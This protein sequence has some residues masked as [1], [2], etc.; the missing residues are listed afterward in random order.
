VASDW[1]R[2]D[3]AAAKYGPQLDS[4]ASRYTDPLTGKRLTGEAL[5]RKTIKL[6]SGGQRDAVSSAGARGWAQFMP[7]TRAAVIH[8]FGVDP[9]R[10][11]EE[12]VQALVLHQRGK[13]GNATGLE[14]YNPGGGRAYVNEVLGARVGPGRGGRGGVT[15]APTAGAGGAAGNATPGGS[16]IAS[17]SPQIVSTLLSDTQQPAQVPVSAPAA[18]SFAA[19]PTLPQGA[20]QPPSSGGAPQPPQDTL[21]AKL[22]A[23]AQLGTD[24]PPDQQPQQ[25]DGAAPADGG[26]G[27]TSTPK[28]VASFEGAKVA[29]WIAPAL[30]YARDHGWKGKVNSGSGRSPTRRASTTRGCVRR[31]S[32]ARRTMRARISRAARSTSATPSSCRRSCRSPP[33]PPSW[34]GLA[35][36]IRS[37]SR[38]R[39][40]A[41]TDMLAPGAAVTLAIVAAWEAWERL[42]HSLALELAVTAAGVAGAG[43]LWKRVILP[44]WRTL[45]RIDEINDA[46]RVL[47]EWMQA[48]EQWR[49]EREAWEAEIELRLSDGSRNFDIIEG[50][51]R[52]LMSADRQAIQDAIESRPDDQDP[53]G[54]S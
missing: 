22:D 26:G 14:G 38:T 23:I 34:C 8:Q 46:V 45:R 24:L 19:G 49:D 54:R 47:P 16:A 42:A 43:V 3:A 28:G 5:I 7:G 1:A 50:Q 31:R 48:R 15:S 30:Q 44:A 17:I 4:V 32:R 6:E 2:I 40:A 51:L 33:T 20:L 13:L 35:G 53:R 25:Q 39:T 21:A 9:W 12:A 41:R 37:T 36:R 52:L 27:G 29:A 11:P 10:S 18:P